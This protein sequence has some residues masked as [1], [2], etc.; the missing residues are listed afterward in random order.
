MSKTVTQLTETTTLDTNDLLHLVDVSAGQDKK[1]KASNLWSGKPY[2]EVYTYNN[3]TNTASPLNTAVF[4]TNSSAWTLTSGLLNG[5]TLNTATG[6]LT[7]TGAE[8][9]IVSINAFLSWHF[10]TTGVTT[11]RVLAEVFLNGTVVQKISVQDTLTD[12]ADTPTT[13]SIS[14]LISITNGDVIA[15]KITNK[16]NSNAVLI[17]N[18]NLNVKCL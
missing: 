2:G 7:Y 11:I 5:F 16:I 13:T 15:V 8:N 3:A 18:F 10:I 4:V 17:S 12:D 9:I 14:G 1:I 6:E